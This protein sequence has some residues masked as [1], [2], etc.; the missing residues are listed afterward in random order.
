MGLDAQDLDSNRNIRLQEKLH[1]ILAPLQQD[2]RAYQS[3]DETERHTLAKQLKTS[4]NPDLLADNLR[5]VMH[6]LD[7]LA[8]G[9]VHEFKRL[10][11][12]TVKFLFEDE[13]GLVPHSLK[14]LRQSNVDNSVSVET[15]SN[16][17]TIWVDLKDKVEDYLSNLS[18]KTEKERDVLAQKITMFAQIIEEKGYRWDTNEPLGVDKDKKLTGIVVTDSNRTAHTLDLAGMRKLMLE[19]LE[20]KVQLERKPFFS[21]VDARTDHDSSSGV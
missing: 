8:V 19:A 5:S 6:G 3:A 18:M 2:W 21:T 7:S 14:S 15:I 16:G 4:F 9:G 17:K 11:L 1:D 13:N 12:S 10:G 20:T